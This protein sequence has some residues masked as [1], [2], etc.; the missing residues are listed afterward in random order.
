MLYK[1]F[2]DVGKNKILTRDY[3]VLWKEYLHFILQLRF[4]SKP[5]SYAAGMTEIDAGQ[6]HKP[7]VKASI[8]LKKEWKISD[9]GVSIS[10][11][12]YLWDNMDSKNN[13]IYSCHA[14]SLQRP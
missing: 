2:Y 10:N 13:L 4:I 14:L 3:T 11:L 9:S 7:R 5:Y 12:I 1:L 6:A 8:L